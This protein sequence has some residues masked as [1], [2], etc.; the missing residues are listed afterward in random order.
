MS[1]S[2]KQV[3]AHAGVSMS[4]VSR[5][6]SGNERA[7][8]AIDTQVSVRRAAEELGY[9]PNRFARSLITGRTHTLGLMVSRL[10]NP[11]FVTLIQGAEEAAK[12]EGYSVLIDADGALAEDYAISGR[13]TGWPVDGVVMWTWTERTLADYIGS[14]AAQTPVLYICERPRPDGAGTVAC[15]ADAGTRES[16]EYALA[17]GY[18]RPAHLVPYEPGDWE[19]PPTRALIYQEMFEKAGVPLETILLNKKAETR[20]AGFLTGLS[21]AK[22]PA[23]DRPDVL[24]CHNDI[25]AVGVYHGLLRC[26]LKVPED[27]AV[28]GFDGIDEGRFLDKRLTTTEIDIPKIGRSAVEMLVANIEGRE[29]PRTTT[30]PAKFVPGETA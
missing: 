20:E 17:R 8:I 10:D 13:L 6:L 25:I 1:I 23:G 9:R 11:F 12:R 16:V 19:V 2:L 7:Q 15:D 4:T 21:M 27:I 24:L 3:A 5:V 28:I 14:R 29:T 18:R 30:V 26:G 22:R